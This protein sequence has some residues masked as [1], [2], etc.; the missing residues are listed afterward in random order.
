MNRKRNIL[1]VLLITAVCILA[2]V[3]T[4]V[5][6]NREI[7]GNEL[8]DRNLV[9][10]GE[11]PLVAFTTVALGGF[12]G[13]AADVLWLRALSLQDQGRYFE[14]VQLADWIQKLQPKFTTVSSYLAWNMAYNISVTCQDFEDRWRWINR[15]IETLRKA[16]R[17]SQND[18]ALYK[19]LGWIYQHKMGNVLDDA[20]QLY[21]YKMA[22]AMIKTFG[23][24]DPDLAALDSAPKTLDELKAASP[25][26]LKT[27]FESGVT[28]LNTLEQEFRV[29]GVLPAA[30]K[31]SLLPKDFKLFDTYLRAKTLRE[32]YLL[33]PERMKR[34]SETY[35]ELDWVL[36]ETHAIYWAEEGLRNSPNGRD[37][38]CERM[39]SQAIQV[40]GESGRM[41]LPD[42]KASFEY[43]LVPNFSIID[44][45]VETYRKA[46]EANKKIPSFRHGYENYL[47]YLVY[48]NY[49][50]AQDDAAHRYFAIL[51]DELKHPEA[52]NNTFDE[53]VSK[54]FQQEMVDSGYKRTMQNVTSTIIRAC[55]HAAVNDKTGALRQLQ[56]AKLLYDHFRTSFA[57]EQER[58]A[59]P[60]FEKY[61]SGIVLNLIKTLEKSNPETA[62][63]IKAE[64]EVERAFDAEKSVK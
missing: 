11:D 60:E 34:M 22:D 5:L 31:E 15:G 38:D 47:L 32:V 64:I 21:K 44:K 12:R 54:R 28:D 53:Y 61:K 2:L 17:M 33:E 4:Q 18:P 50:Y 3:F 6:L 16:I 1:A 25:E 45:S 39:I 10:T 26:L 35:G 59:M 8:V 27:L 37:T 41:L 36:P 58:L 9:E 57:N 42:G 29:S 19:E 13:L 48:L 55:Q 46:Y 14:L 62:A 7:R 52:V 24:R 43:L 49:L 30:L 23:Q 63:R 56:L 20:Q 40:L 51:R